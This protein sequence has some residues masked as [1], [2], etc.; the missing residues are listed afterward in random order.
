MKKLCGFPPKNRKKRDNNGISGGLVVGREKRGNIENIYYLSDDVHSLT[1]GATRSGKSRC[2]VLQSIAHTA[3][4]GESLLVNDPKGELAAYCAPF[5]KRLDYE[6]VLLDFKS[7]LKSSRYN[8]LQP[9]IDAVNRGDNA[10]AVDL[11]WDV[12]SALVPQDEKGEKI[13]NDGQAAII[14]GAIMSVVF[15]NRER[16]EFQNLTNVYH[17]ILHMCRAEGDGILLDKYLQDMPDEHPAK[18]LFGVAQIAPSRTRGS[19]FTA[20]LATLRLFTNESVYSQTSASDFRLAD[21]GSRKRAIFIILPDEKVTFYSLASLLVYQQ[22]VA[23]TEAADERG[24]RLKVRVNFL[25]DE[26]GNFVEIPAFSNLLT[27]GGGRGCRFNLFIQSISQIEQKYGREQCQTILDNCHCWIYLKTA[28]VETASQ[29]SK[30]LGNYTTSSYSRSSS[31]SPGG[32]SNGNI[33]NSFNLISRPLLTEDEILRIERPY[34]LVM[35]SG[36]FSAIMKLPDLSEWN[37]NTALG[38]GDPE[39]NRKLR[40]LREK[41]REY[42]KPEPIKLWGIWDKYAKKTRTSSDF[43]EHSGRILER[44]EMIDDGIRVIPARPFPVEMTARD[45]ALAGK[46]LDGMFEK[47]RTGQLI[48]QKD[49]ERAELL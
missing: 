27:V 20:A 29:I 16:S 9:V 32:G 11:T 22:Y 41:S 49:V 43:G 28:N 1:I 42:R 36:H 4:A 34:A 47:F 24:G 26:F 12:T 33:S 7:P 23:L 38:M 5:L 40:E 6:V 15:D 2:I 39:H 18:G 8:F 48:R 3:L 37:F 45:L 35:Y 25:L 44:D 31:Y 10:K 30:R 19:F 14:A 46:G 17:F 13:W 21:T